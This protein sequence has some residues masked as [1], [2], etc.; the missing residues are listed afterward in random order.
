MAHY[1]KGKSDGRII[2]TDNPEYWRGAEYEALSKKAGSI[3]A[4][5]QARDDLRKII[6]PGSTVTCI[7][8]HVSRSGMFRIIALCVCDN[9]EPRDISSLAAKATGIGYDDNR[10]GLKMGGCGMDMGFAA[11]YDLSR[12]LYRDKFQCIG[13][14]CPSNDHS[15]GDRNRKPHMHSDGGYALRHRWL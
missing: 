15:N 14:K 2:E 11:V 10:Y 12:A 8:R 9:G 1:F 3:A 7:L 4:Q 13:E 5:E 6:P